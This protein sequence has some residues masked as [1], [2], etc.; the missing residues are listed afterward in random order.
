MP[1][2]VSLHQSKNLEM[3]LGGGFSNG[4]TPIIFLSPS[5]VTNP[6]PVLTIGCLTNNALA[7]VPVSFGVLA[8]SCKSTLSCQSSSILGAPFSVMSN[9]FEIGI[10][11]FL[12]IL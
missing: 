9:R 2:G 12:D 10:E 3:V 1:S 8:F 6:L 4:S 11:G 7:S 5:P